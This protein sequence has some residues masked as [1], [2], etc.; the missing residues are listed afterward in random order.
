MIACPEEIAYRM[1]FIDIDALAALG[2]AHAQNEYGAY[3]VDLARAGAPGMT[4]TLPAGAPLK[5]GI[6]GRANYPLLQ[7]RAAV[8]A[9]AGHDVHVLSLEPGTVPGATVHL[10]RARASAARC[11]T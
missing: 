4:T 10:P 2:Q 5:I 11:A 6:A 9:E 7:R 8:Y 1:G 3:L